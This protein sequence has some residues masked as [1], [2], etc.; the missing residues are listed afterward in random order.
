M[1]YSNYTYS[2]L[3]PLVSLILE[4]CENPQKHHA[5]I[6]EK[7]TDKRFK[8]ASLFVEAE[9]KKGFRALDVAKDS[10]TAHVNGTL[11]YGHSWKQQ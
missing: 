10:F 3:Y 8:R 9:V 6:F 1:Y 11:D 7:Y 2:Q 5:A 4:C